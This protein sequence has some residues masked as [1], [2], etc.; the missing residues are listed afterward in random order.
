MPHQCACTVCGTQYEAQRSTS[1]YCSTK[2]RT[3]AS[4]AGTSRKKEPASGQVV[5]QLPV[6]AAPP[7][8]AVGGGSAADGLPYSQ[9]QLTIQ[10]LEAAGRLD[11]AL[12]M[13][14]VILARRIDSNHR[15][16][17]S[18][19]AALVRQLEASM[20]SATVN[21][22][23]SEDPVQRAKDELAARRQRRRA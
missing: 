14:C 12:G 10:E 22:H 7:A 2:C 9:E 15:E 19:V 21:A 4:R 8:D 13:S 20:R 23:A 1:R 3:R 16:T 5:T 11:T 6:A 18:G 17:G